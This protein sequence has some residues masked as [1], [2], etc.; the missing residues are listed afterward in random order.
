MRF[1]NQTHRYY[2]GVDLH[3][4][5]MYLC[6]L[7]SAGRPVSSGSRQVAGP[8]SC[9]PLPTAS[10]RLP[11]A[12]CLLPTA[13]CRLAKGEPAV[14]LGRPGGTDEILG[15][16]GTCFLRRV[17]AWQRPGRLTLKMCLVQLRAETPSRTAAV[18]HARR[19][20]QRPAGNG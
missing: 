6:I 19:R 4:R 17:R 9:C 2:C 1:Y 5:T 3:A 15:R 20:Q 14:L 18:P 13:S 11:A 12:D 7:D 10:C 8:K 16:G